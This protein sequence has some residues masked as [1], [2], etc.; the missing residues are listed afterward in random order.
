MPPVS[1]PL[2][3]VLDA[4]RDERFARLTGLLADRGHA[5]AGGVWGS[6][7]A[8]L[9]VAA[10]QTGQERVLVVTPSVERFEDVAEDLAAF[11]PGCVLPFPPLEAA[12]PDEE[13]VVTP[14]QGLRVRAL[15]RLEGDERVLA[16]CAPLQSLLDPVPAPA[17]LARCRVVLEKGSALD[18]EA[19]A[20]RLLESGF[21]HAPL[22]EEPG[23]FSRRGGILDLYPPTADA[24]VRVEV[25]GD[26][27]A[28]VRPFDPVTQRS[29]APVERCRVTLVPA[30]AHRADR[31]GP[32]ATL[33]DYLG[34][35]TVFVWEPEECRARTRSAADTPEAGGDRFDRLMQELT[36]HRVALVRALP[37]ASG[38]D[39]VIFDMEPAETT[40]RDAPAVVKELASLAA[41]LRRTLL[42]CRNEGEAQRFRELAP[43]KAG[44]ETAIGALSAGFV[45]RAAGC[46][47][48][49][50]RE[51]FKRY[52][53]RREAPP[54]RRGMP[55]E[56]IADMQPG[57]VVVHTVHGIARFTGLVRL[58]KN[59]RVQEFLQLRFAEGVRVYVPVAQVDLVHRYVGVG[60]AEPQLSRLKTREWAARKKKAAAA[61]ADV[62][63]ELLRIQAVREHQRGLSCPEDGEWQ[64]RFESE[65]PYEETPDQLVLAE[66]I[67]RDM[68]AT[69]PM[70]RLVCGDVGYGKTELAMRA[71]FRAVMTGRQVAV[72]VP[73]T[74][75][76][77]Q[78]ARTFGERMAD[79]PVQIEMLSRFRTAAE[80]AGVV[81]RLA[82]GGVDIVIGTHRLLQKDIAFRDLGLVIIDEEQRFGV[83]HKERLKSLRVTVDVLTMT[84]T[85]IP[86]TLHMSLVGLRDISSLTTPPR[87]RLAIHTRL[88]RESPEI[89]R[90]AI[91]R[92]LHRDGQVYFV[93]NRVRDIESVAADVRATVPEASVGVAHGQMPEKLL[94]ERMNAFM[95]GTLNVLVCTTI[96]ESGLDIPNANTMII[97]DADIYGLSDLHQLRG[98]VGRYRHRAY[99]LLLL[100]GRRPVNPIAQKRLRAI[101]QYS[102]LGAGFRIALRD[103]EI[104][105]VGNI[106]GYEQSGHIAA[107]GYEMYCRLLEESVSRLRGTARPER[108][109]AVVDL[110]VCNVVPDAYLPTG[111]QKL[112]VYRKAARANVQAEIRDLREELLDRYGAP[113]PEADALLATARI[114]VAA[115]ECGIAY[116][117]VSHG[118]IIFRGPS[119]NA[120]AA[121]LHPAGGTVRPVEPGLV[122]V[123]P[124]T[125]P[126]G[127][128]EL[129]AFVEGCLARGRE[130]ISNQ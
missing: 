58:K 122:H 9:A 32:T 19:L 46:G 38:G 29:R 104:R 6:G 89:V 1:D 103:M 63:A 77:Q 94:A 4:V 56:E 24:P 17:S 105:G 52:A 98:R 44:V 108:R 62:A 78:H 2:A 84:A 41:G 81:R 21:E 93:H 129:L 13:A 79:Y 12:G 88:C 45:L 128:G 50:H 5:V 73:T 8:A 87:D 97:H 126:R 95:G 76:A 116:V 118:D 22:T 40:K 117:G 34:R 64:H 113:P 20:T 14:E 65:F 7:L 119:D 54:P 85:P 100:P 27:I 39:E 96:I 130:V 16:A 67:R 70:D 72:L 125:P 11:L 82:E 55:I 59:E 60:G 47:I 74:I 109:A 36:R 111:R 80:Q 18:P 112:E 75:L 115:A 127:D 37:L 42:F 123:R 57:D 26:E 3:A 51:V 90:D 35:A 114:R 43:P 53:V 107:V 10:A 101:V 92:E 66:E 86:R 15:E 33:A 25:L 69:Q 48:F 23:Q 110:N 28:S 102:D 61:V 99:A 121:R 83:A 120:F 30:E 49:T 71:A 68:Q 124:G 91:L 31:D 106:L